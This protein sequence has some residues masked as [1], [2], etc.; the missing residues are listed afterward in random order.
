MRLSVSLSPPPSVSSAHRSLPFGRLLTAAVAAVVVVLPGVPAAA[1]AATTPPS[2]APPGDHSFPLATRIRGGP[3]SYEAGGGYGTWYIDLTNTT[4]RTCTDVHPVV[5]LVDDHHVLQPSQPK[6][7]FYDGSRIRPVRFRRT[8]EDELVGVLDGT[9][10]A[11]FTVGPGKTVS[12]RVRLSVTSDAVPDRVTVN[13]AVVQRRGADGDWIGESNDYAF[14][15][16]DGGGDST[17]SAPPSS[18]ST[19]S[20]LPS[21]GATDETGQPAWELAGTGIGLAEG[22]LAATAALLAAGA[23]AFVVARGRR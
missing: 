11:G 18:T 3:A 22:L 2:C 9:G 12:V 8:D 10:F 6:L 1:L 21:P 14:G 13:A 15:I 5:V 23:T 16:G 19:G 20:A 17:P 7:D 4:R